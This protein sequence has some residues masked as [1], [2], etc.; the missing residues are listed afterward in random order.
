MRNFLFLLLIF[1]ALFIVIFPENSTGFSSG[2]PGGK[3]NSPIDGGNCTDCHSGIINSGPGNV[4]LNTDIQNFIYTPGQ[5]YSFTV[6]SSHPSFTKYGFELTA[7]SFGNKVGGFSIVN[8][9]QTKLLNNGESVT[10]KITGTTGSASKSWTVNWTAPQSS[11]PFTTIDFYVTS[12]T[13]N[14]NNGNSGDQTYSYQYTVNKDNSTNINESEIYT[15]AYF[16]D[17]FLYV[18]S[19]SNIDELSIYDINGKKVQTIN[20]YQSMT[21]IYGLSSG[22]YIIEFIDIFKNKKLQK[23]VY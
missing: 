11:S 5:T 23:I 17:G 8:S 14:G 6:I 4:I 1:F 16:F 19:L 3:T 13:A 15:N 2:S 21:P 10:H 20:N 9:S 12:L 22:I 18:N 7:E